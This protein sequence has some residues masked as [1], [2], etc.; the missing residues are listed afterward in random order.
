M[1]TYIF[2]MIRHLR[3]FIEIVAVIRQL[4]ET[5]ISY[6]TC[7]DLHVAILAAFDCTCDYYI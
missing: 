2:H 3:Q 5:F 1:T 6:I 7:I 4:Q